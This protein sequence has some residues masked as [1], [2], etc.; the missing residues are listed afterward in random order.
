MKRLI[1]F[2]LLI[3]N[4]NLYSQ[5]ICNNGIDD[6]LDGLID[7]QDT[8]DCFCELSQ[9]D[10]S[11]SS[12]IPNPSFDQR[13]CCPSA[14]S[15]LNCVN[16]W[17][18]ASGATS[19][20]FNSCGLLAVGTFPPPPTPLPNGTGYVGFFDDFFPSA[21][22]II[23]KEYLGTCLTD[24]MKI[25]VNY[26]VEFFLANS[27]GN[28]TTEIAIYGATNCTNLPFGN[29]LP[30]ASS[31][32]P[33]TVTPANWMILAFDT[34]TCSSSSWV[35]VTLNFTATQN[36]TAIVLGPS[37]TNNSGSNYY[38]IDNLTLNETSLFTPTVSISDSGHYC[39]ENLK[40]KA[41]FDSIPLSFQWYKDGIALVGETDSNY[42]VLIGGIGAYQVQLL[43]DSG[44]VITKPFNVIATSVTFDI[45]SSGSCPVGPS[46]GKIYVSNIQ[47]GT[48]P[49]TLSLNSI[50]FVT[51][52]FF[53]QLSPGNYLLTVR[54]SN[55][56]ESSQ[57]IMIGAF[58]MPVASFITDSICLGEASI[59]MDNSY[60]SKG[61]INQWGWNV[62]GNPTTQN[63]TIIY[64]TDG[65][66][67]ITHIVVSDSG[68][69][70]DTTINVVVN[71][72]PIAD[73]TFNPKEIYT[74]NPGVC[75][76]N[77]STG[78][79]NYYWDFDFIG[80]T[81]NSLLTNPCIVQFPSNQEKTYNVK[82]L[83]TSDKGCLDSVYVSVIVLDE[84]LLYVPNSFSPN[85]D[86]INDDFSVSATGI[87]SYE[88]LIFNNW[89]E[90]IYSSSDP[91]D[92]WDGKFNGAIVPAGV[93]IYKIRLKAENREVR[94]K[95][96]HINI[97]H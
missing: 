59:L 73:F 7:L 24:T 65:V 32:C 14:A 88:I 51:D 64:G 47:G 35:R 36:Y 6:D 39:Q 90:L 78:A 12:L 23:Y 56:C 20:Y 62:P 33:T 52:T 57:I 45:D 27:F 70:D 38:Y 72:L 49:Y 29:L 69:I 34:A 67:S 21:N 43:Y 77:L 76:T 53:N 61:S 71:P 79:I 4:F 11:I 13:S 31:L 87:D 95:F 50:T 1:L 80:A 94:E 85:N 19:D 10:S 74:F 44:C 92:S 66:Y 42:S 97:L 68:C 60:I 83:V 81:G 55:L 75:F 40:L 9:P 22:S 17:I 91:L 86:D 15:Q 58:N 28:L 84:F 26:Q 25:G 3:I 54:D 46:T 37:C 16:N 93:Y 82:L 30:T 89:G 18:Q 96:G 48:K 8:T 63:T 5:E 41:D 2:L